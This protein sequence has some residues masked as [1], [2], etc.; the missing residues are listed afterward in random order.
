MNFNA[1]QTVLM[2]QH[3]K[4]GKIGSCG[5][6]L[7]ASANKGM[8][9]DVKGQAMGVWII[10]DKNIEDNHLPE[11]S[12]PI[13]Y[14]NGIEP[15]DE[16]LLSPIIFGET[17]KARIRNC[18]Y[19]NLNRKFFHSFV[20]ELLKRMDRNFNTVASGQGAW[21]VD[22]DGKLLRIEDRDDK[23]YNEDNTGIGWLVEVF[24][25]IKFKD[26]GSDA[27]KKMLDMLDS[28]TDD[29]IFISKWAVIPVFYRD[30]EI[31]GNSRKNSEINELYT[32]ILKYARSFDNEVLS[33]SRHLTL[34]NIQETLVKLR[35]LGQSL[36]EKKKGMLQKNILG[37]S[38]DYGGRGVISVPSLDGCNLPSDCQVNIEHSGIPLGYCIVLGYP[39]MIKWVTE[40]FEDTFRNK[41]TIPHY[42]KNRKGEYELKY[43]EI[44]DQTEIFTQE[45]INE[46]MT[47]YK[48]TYGSERFDPIKIKRAD[49]TW[50]DLYFPGRWYGSNP[51]DPR[52]NS[53][54]HRPMTWTD[55][56]YL[57]A[58]NTLSDKHCYIT[59]Y[60]L[61]DYF[62]IFPSRVAVLSTIKTIP[63]IIDGKV[64]PHYPYIDLSLP[65]NQ[66]A[67]QFIDTFSISNLYLDA[68]GGDYDGDTV[69]A[70]ILF[71]IEANEEAE[72]QLHDIKHYVSI[73]GK[74]VRILS[75]EA[76]L[77]FY[78]MTRRE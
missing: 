20:Y 66:I 74:L 77:S 57:A 18:A 9:I 55:V 63:V 70:K 25:S 13:L 62:G 36:I 72:K 35:N 11:V 64:Y 30:V 22:E 58:V 76:Y 16:G 44:V 46:K 17:A 45:Y 32:S 39:F 71:S 21:I 68:I 60:P 26:T 42:V 41:H 48:Q 34:Y 51:N 43:D 2:P 7:E 5:I 54:S 19:I 78:N 23:R 65:K 27:R 49:G 56:F 47:M 50:G 6:V 53:I 28:L 69:S 67:T 15:T 59:R 4:F 75:N 12:D 33:V 10:T 1:V 38:T 73:Q 29:E 61:E 24:H 8:T 31:Q 37:K 14:K 40:F 3:P 52:A